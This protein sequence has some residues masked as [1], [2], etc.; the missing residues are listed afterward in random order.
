MSGKIEC[1]G[2]V[3]LAGV[4]ITSLEGKRLQFVVSDCGG[5][6]VDHS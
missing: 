5:F 3:F 4:L 2:G 6:M 1:E